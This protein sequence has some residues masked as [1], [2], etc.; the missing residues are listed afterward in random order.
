MPSFPRPTTMAWARRVVADSDKYPWQFA[1][2]A[3]SAFWINF[4]KHCVPNRM[5]VIARRPCFLSRIFLSKK[6]VP[7]SNVKT[8]QFVHNIHTYAHSLRKWFFGALFQP[9]A[10]WFITK[11]EGRLGEYD[12]NIRMSYIDRW[13]PE[14]QK[15]ITFHSPLPCSYERPL[16]IAISI[17]GDHNSKSPNLH[18]YLTYAT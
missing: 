1:S 5:Y 13:L 7:Y 17:I 2:F 4:R 10:H 14:Q 11:L 3:E 18:K 16:Q 12:S 9:T 6:K 8:G 15:I